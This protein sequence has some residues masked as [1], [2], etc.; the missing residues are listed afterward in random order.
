MRVQHNTIKCL[1]SKPHRCIYKSIY[2]YIY[3]NIDIKYGITFELLIKLSRKLDKELL[4]SCRCIKM[5]CCMPSMLLCIG[6]GGGVTSICGIYGEMQFLVLSTFWN[7]CGY[8]YWCTLE[9]LFLS[10]IYL[11]FP[12]VTTNLSLYTLDFM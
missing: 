3:I 1:L 12:E 5:Y 10:S 11:G 2:I 4:I 6:G 8:M 9:C 7:F